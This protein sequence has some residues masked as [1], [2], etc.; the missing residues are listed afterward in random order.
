M[1]DFWYP[2]SV[3]QLDELLEEFKQKSRSEEEISEKHSGSKNIFGEKS[4]RDR[5]IVLDDVSGLA[6]ESKKFARF[7]VVLRKYSYNCVYIFHSIHT[8]K[9]I[10]RTILSQTNIYSIFRATVPFNRVKKILE[11][12]CIRKAS[13]YILQSALWICRLFIELAKRNEKICLTLDCSNTNRD[14]P[15]RFR[16]EVDNPDFQ[17][18][19]FINSADNEQI[20]NEFVSERIKSS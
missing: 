10:W 3:D 16:T 6:D 8:E 17:A 11:G 12:A 15:G 9:T 13:K 14:G 5:L 1:V 7:L 18:C 20:Y 19:Y 4:N 2:C